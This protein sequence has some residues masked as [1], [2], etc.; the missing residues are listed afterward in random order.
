MAGY[1][2]RPVALACSR[3]IA[4]EHDRFLPG[5]FDGRADR[6]D[7]V[8]VEPGREVRDEPQDALRV[9]VDVVLL[10]GDPAPTGKFGADPE[11]DGA[12][13]HAVDG[14]VGVDLDTL[15]D[16]ALEVD[17]V[18]R[19]PIFEEAADREHRGGD[20]GA[21]RRQRGEACGG[22]SRRGGRRAGSGGGQSGEGHGDGTGR[23]RPDRSR[24]QQGFLLQVSQTMT[25]ELHRNRRCSPVN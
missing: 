13:P 3:S 19:A 10:Q 14:V 7:V 5:K 12:Q 22:L 6:D 21:D 17:G 8:L 18:G 16:A 9:D 1:W 2:V 20:L 25:G 23:E 4:V 15:F 11:P 24:G